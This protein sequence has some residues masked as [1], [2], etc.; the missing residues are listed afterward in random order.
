[1]LVFGFYI[2]HMENCKQPKETI[3]CIRKGSFCVSCTIH[4]IH[5][6]IFLYIMECP[7]EWALSPFENHRILIRKELGIHL[8]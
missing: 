7:N 5:R 8:A 2:L 6:Q 3:I 4:F 1:M